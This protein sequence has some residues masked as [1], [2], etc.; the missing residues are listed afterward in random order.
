MVPLG[1]TQEGEVVDMEAV[2]EVDVVEEDATTMVVTEA[3]GAD[4]EAGDVVGGEVAVAVVK[5]N[6][7]QSPI[8]TIPAK[9]TRR[10]LLS[11][12]LNSTNSEK[13]VIQT[14]KLV[15]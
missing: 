2:G 1:L 12:V 7:K 6:L 9:N 8:A 14:V 4:M 11:S 5:D 10:L 15:P 13:H 3:K